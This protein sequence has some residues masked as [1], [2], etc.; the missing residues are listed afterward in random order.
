M[1]DKCP[2]WGTPAQT[3]ATGDN[4]DV[5]SLRSG[6]EYRLTGTAAKV[7]DACSP[8]VKARLTTW[9]V[10]QRRA[11]TNKPVINVDT[12]KLSR[13]RR[14]LSLSDRKERLFRAIRA[15]N[16]DL[17]FSFKLSGTVDADY[18]IWHRHLAAWTESVS[19]EGGDVPRLCELAEEDG[20]L[21]RHGGHAYLTSQGWSY[22]EKLGQVG[23]DTLQ[24][25]VAMWFSPE[26]Q[27]AYDKGISLAIRDAGYLPLRIDAKEHN[28]KIDD[29]IIAEI[30]LSRFIVADF[31]AGS[32]TIDGGD[33]HLPRGGVYYEAGFA[34][35]LGMEVVSCVRADQVEK[36]HFDTRQISHVLWDTPEILRDRLYSRIVATVGPAPNAPGRGMSPSPA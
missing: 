30:K 10:D 18:H 35:G 33:I 6:G 34:K 7:L 4:T 26:M 24:V 17:H 11:G 16:P 12:L 21:R 23:A 9:L 29:E 3:L 5:K 25:F 1:N 36:V 32:T 2:I 20:L 15:T 31:T 22:V 8:E 28:N 27:A 19:P 14:P 13:D